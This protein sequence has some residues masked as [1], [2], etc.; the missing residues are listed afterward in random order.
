MAW[1]ELSLLLLGTSRLM[2]FMSHSAHRRNPASLFVAS[3]L[4]LIVI[5][6]GLLMLPGSQTEPAKALP[7]VEQLR[8]A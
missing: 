6:T 8:I 5:G 1:S 4:V 7:L 3:F 2:L